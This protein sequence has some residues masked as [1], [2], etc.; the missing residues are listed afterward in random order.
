MEP[1]SNTKAAVVLVTLAVVAVVG[2]GVLAY[3][4]D[5]AARESRAELTRSML[6]PAALLLRENEALLRELQS[7]PFAEQGTGIIATYLGKIRRDRVGPHAQM[8]QRLDRLADNN[9]AIVALA[10]AYVPH[11]RSPAFN[12]EAGRYQSYAAAWGDRW[13]SVMEL[14]MLGG[15]LPAADVPYPKGLAEAVQ[16]ELEAAK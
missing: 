1:K 4:A 5:V 16:G 2:A 9:V 7:P 13:H 10:G 6:E 12:G 11:A 8:R 3:R 15:N 14:F